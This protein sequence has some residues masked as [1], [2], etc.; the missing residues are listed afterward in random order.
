MTSC[1]FSPFWVLLRIGDSRC[2]ASGLLIFAI[3]VFDSSFCPMFY[4][5]L[6][7]FIRLKVDAIGGPATE[8][9]RSNSF[10]VS[11]ILLSVLRTPAD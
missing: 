4:E 1:D 8:I 2:S 3:E 6:A 10:P 5:D 11:K 9:E 7:A